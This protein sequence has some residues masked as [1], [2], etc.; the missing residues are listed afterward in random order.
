MAMADDTR[1]KIS[2]A[3]SAEVKDMLCADIQASVP[4]ALSAEIDGVTGRGV[5]GV[6]LE[7]GNIV[8]VMTDG[9]SINIGPL[10][11]PEIPIASA[12]VPGIVRVGGNLTI[13]E[14]GRLSADVSQSVSQGDTKPVSGGAVYDMV[15][16]IETALS[17]L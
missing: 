8:F 12:E 7:N 6:T 1:V 15:G 3:L 9:D 10:P 4:S 16:N 2:A 5:A 17:V 13:D 14:N 11:E